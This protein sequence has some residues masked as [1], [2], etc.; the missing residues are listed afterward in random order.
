MVGDRGGPW[1]YVVGQNS[2]KVGDIRLLGRLRPSAWPTTAVYIRYKLAFCSKAYVQIICSITCLCKQD[3]EISLSNHTQCV[4]D[5]RI[6]ASCPIKC[7]IPTRL[8]HK[9]QSVP[10]YMMLA[11]CPIKCL[12]LTNLRSKTTN[13]V[14]QII[15]Y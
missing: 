12:I 11:S 4:P 3:S 8:R 5:Y 10:D 6:L 2:P 13:N 14:Y 1:G 15:G 9:H 7:L